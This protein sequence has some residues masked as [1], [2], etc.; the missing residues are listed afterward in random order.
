MSVTH[1]ESPWNPMWTMSGHIQGMMGVQRLQYDIRCM[2]GGES[3][4][5]SLATE[6][7]ENHNILTGRSC[8]KLSDGL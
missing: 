3:H 4:H 6:H 2:A 7:F 1:T 5:L 8:G